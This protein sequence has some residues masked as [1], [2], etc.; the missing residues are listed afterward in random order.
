MV[1]SKD[2]LTDDPGLGTVLIDSAAVG[3]KGKAQ[4]VPIAELWCDPVLQPRDKDSV[5]KEI[6]VK[7]RSF[8]AQ[9]YLADQPIMVEEREQPN[10]AGKY[11]VL[12]GHCRTGAAHY[13]LANQPDDYARIFHD[14]KIPAVIVKG[15]TDAQRVLAAIDQSDDLNR[16]PLSKYE[17]FVA[18]RAMVK[19]GY[20]SQEGIAAKLGIY[21]LEKESGKQVPNRSWVQIRVNLARLPQFIQDEYEVLEKRGEKG[22]AFRVPMIAK[23]YK[24]Y[25]ENNMDEKS[26][27]FLAVWRECITPKDSKS[28]I[29]GKDR[30]FDPFTPVELDT[31]LGDVAGSDELRGIVRALAGREPRGVIIANVATIVE[32][33]NVLR[34]IRLA[35]GEP[36]FAD[37]VRDAHAALKAE[38]ETETADTNGE[39]VEA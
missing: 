25:R 34:G 30:P 17:Q 14:G 29:K 36:V 26:D 18:V 6:P 4:R 31:L 12:R 7:V 20:V 33:G 15:L 16:R 35:V 13:L 5:E 23:L 32:T 28:N 22:T 11:C 19:Q 37:L 38:S 39:L 24:S 21:S 10:G 2:N 1:A 8:L 27:N 9:G 3:S